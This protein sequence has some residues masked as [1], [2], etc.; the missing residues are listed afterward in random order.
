MLES[1]GVEPLAASGS[2]RRGDGLSQ[3][4]VDLLLCGAAVAVAAATPIV[5]RT[6]DE[7]IPTDVEE[8]VE[9]RLAILDVIVLDRRGRTVPDLQPDEF[10]VTV[11]GRDVEI[12]SV[13]VSCPIGETDDPAADDN[14]SDAVVPFSRPEAAVHPFR[15]VLGFDFRHFGR[16]GH[17]APVTLV[18]EIVDRI[19]ETLR[20]E[21]LPGEETMIVSMGNGLRIETPFTSDRRVVLESVDR[22]LNDPANFG[23]HFDHLTENAFFSEVKALMDILESVPGRKAVVLFTGPL[24]NGFEYDP[25]FRELAALSATSRVALYPVDS[26]GL[27]TEPMYFPEQAGGPK[28]LARM[29]VETGGRLT[30]N[31]NAVGLGYTRAVRDLACAYEV[32][33]YDNRPRLDKERRVRVWLKR[34]GVRAYHASSYVFRSPENKRRSLITAAYMAPDMFEQGTLEARV[35]PFRPKSGRK[36]ETLVA[37]SFPVLDDAFVGGVAR[38]DFGGVIRS[39]LGTRLRSFNRRVE[40]DRSEISGERPAVVFMERV[41]LRPG[42]YRLN[43]VQSH[44]GTE[45]PLALTTE[46]DLPEIP[47][48]EPFLVGPILGRPAGGDVLILG[49][50]LDTPDGPDADVVRSGE[51]FEPLLAQRAERGD[52]VAALTQLCFVGPD[53]APGDEVIHRTLSTPGRGVVG[54]LPPV[55]VDLDAG[56]GARCRTLLDWLPTQGLPSGTYSLEA[57]PDPVSGL[58]VETVG[59]GFE[60]VDPSAPQP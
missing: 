41:A 3:R 11:N 32:A 25:H 31:T 15:V 57:S 49:R 54:T 5:S 14:L 18:G 29:A 6:E 9:V 39:H 4:F 60:I 33:F 52:T 40:L 28:K 48:G 26:G 21:P 44:A 7:P 30:W 43:V 27:R 24:G 35:F 50:G 38:W 12:A 47:T 51:A 56:R 37:V 8:R 22:V 17:R 36:W 59:V 23:G 46:I 16:T 2:E 58:G 19:K 55:S 45:T 42:R 13:D 20:S 53:D 10:E 1:N 34:P